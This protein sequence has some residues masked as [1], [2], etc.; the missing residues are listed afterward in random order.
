MNFVAAQAR[1]KDGAIGANCV[2]IITAKLLHTRP[3]FVFGKPAK[4]V[5]GKY[6]QVMEVNCSVSCYAG[7][8]NLK[9][10]SARVKP[11]KAANPTG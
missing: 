2:G 11:S 1:L 8:A 6:R 10:R 3:E 7:S 5:G 4:I 9:Y